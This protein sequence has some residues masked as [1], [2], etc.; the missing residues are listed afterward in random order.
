[1][2]ENKVIVALVNS[3]TEPIDVL[4]I[5]IDVG[6]RTS[7]TFLTMIDDGEGGQEPK[8]L[9]CQTFATPDLESLDK[10]VRV[11]ETAAHTEN[12]DDIHVL[13]EGDSAFY[14]RRV[15]H[16]TADESHNADEI[17]QVDRVKCLY[18]KLGDLDVVK[19]DTVSL[20]I[21]HPFEMSE[22]FLGDKKAPKGM[23]QSHLGR[24]FPNLVGDFQV[25]TKHDIDS[26]KTA[27]FGLVRILVI[28]GL[29]LKVKPQFDEVES[30]TTDKAREGRMKHLQN[31]TNQKL[32]LISKSSDVVG[33][34]DDPV[35]VYY[36][37]ATQLTFEEVQKVIDHLQ[38]LADIKRIQEEID[39]ESSP[40]E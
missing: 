29:T 3:L 14:G 12:A 16:L 38:L 21:A 18:D 2:N 4:S 28:Q 19:N 23:M 25:T 5:G 8:L 33:P 36:V 27:L 13:I 30:V 11:V 1:M 26:I 32:D 31:L 40:D 35:T 10:I 39:K 9:F 7:V 15:K 20:E 34:G 22:Y 17:T 37:D 6:Y 24:Y